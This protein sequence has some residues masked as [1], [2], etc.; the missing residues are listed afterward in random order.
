MDMWLYAAI[1][2]FA[3]WTAAFSSDEAAKF[4]T[5]VVLFWVKP[6]CGAIGGTLL[7]IKMY[8]STGFAKH[9]EKK[10]AETHPTP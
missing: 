1:A 8:R 5:A 2:F 6:S 4:I 9:L 7:A 10:E 3:A